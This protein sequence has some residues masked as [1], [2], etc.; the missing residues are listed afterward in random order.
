MSA[1]TAGAP[2]FLLDEMVD[3]ANRIRPSWRRVFEAVQSLGPSLLAE[4]G[5]LLERAAEEEGAASLLADGE[6]PSW[7]CDPVPLVLGAGEF[8]ALARRVAERA[9]ALEAILQDVHGAQTLLADG[10]IPGAVVFGSREFL[11]PCRGN[12]RRRRFLTFYAADLVRAPDGA[13][14]VV[15][16]R[17]ARPAGIGR[18]LENRRLMRRVMPEFFRTEIAGLERF[19]ELWRETLDRTAVPDGARDGRRVLLSEGHRDPGW[20]EDVLLARELGCDLVQGGD[21]TLRGGRLFVKSLRGLR[22]VGIVLARQAPQRLDP[23]E[24]DW[25]DASG[26]PGLL[27]LSR[28]SRVTLLN[29]PGAAFGETPALA[30]FVARAARRLLGT[31]LALPAADT[32]WLGE[33]EARTRFEAAPGDWLIRGAAR[34]DSPLLAVASLGARARGRLARAIASRPGDFV[35]VAATIPSAAPSALADG[36]LDARPIS[37]RLFLLHDGE[38]WVALPSGFVRV[39]GDGETPGGRL[40]RQGRAKDLLVVADTDEDI[41]EGGRGILPAVSPEHG[42]ARG[43]AVL[44]R[45]E[46]DLPARIAEEFFSLGRELEQLETA[47]RVAQLL[48]TRL[49]RFVQRPRELVELRILAACFIRTELL[50]REMLIDPA[51]PGLAAALGRLAAFDGVLAIAVRRTARRIDRLRDRLTGGMYATLTRS[52]AAVLDGFEE[53][54]RA[55]TLESL[56]RVTSAIA[57]FAATLA[58]LAAETMV[59]GGGRLFLELGLRLARA[60]ASVS[61][62]AAGLGPAAALPVPHAT[63]SAAAGP[64]LETAFALLL[65]LRDSTLTYRSRYQGV[66]EPAPVLDLLL[67]DRSNPRALAFQ[68][69]EL[70]TLLGNLGERDGLGLADRTDAMLGTADAIV[71]RVLDAADPDAQAAALPPALAAIEAEIGA[72]GRAIARRYIDLLPAMRSVAS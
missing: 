2:A 50:P 40:P 65:E 9:D 32:L 21:L 56:A 6:A 1:A 72:L 64:D 19:F 49:E 41:W 11:R 53:Q 63:G 16:D 31:T 58:G 35:A 47:S 71:R 61:E 39:L 25:T 3:G 52:L 18:A 48:A 29:D 23:L 67:T 17:C 42:H 5:R 28:A 43:R 26:T 12:A 46:G 60:E 44:R 66:V 7:F 51:A 10:T 69:A 20:F 33:P 45:P 36:T 14:R 4:R 24:L 54:A 62:L 38:R 55:C 70:G 22:P 34:S 13:F 30:P 8:T 59:R 68:L 15:G 57:G 27:A 37:L